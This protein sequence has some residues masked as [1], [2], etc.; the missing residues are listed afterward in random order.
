SAWCGEFRTVVALS[1][2]GWSRS[3]SNLP[4]FEGMA[5]GGLDK[6]ASLVS[7][8]IGAQHREHRVAGESEDHV[9]GVLPHER[10]CFPPT[11]AGDQ[12]FKRLATALIPFNLR[13]C[14]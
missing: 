5:A 6:H 3:A 14:E 8:T 12:N 10:R 7:R 9:D 1:G 11:D 4:R 13:L 2:H